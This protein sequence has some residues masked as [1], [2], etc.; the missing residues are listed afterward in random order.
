[1]DTTNALA[2]GWE[3]EETRKPRIAFMGEF[4][5]G[6]STLSNLLIGAPAL[7][8]KVTATQL[9][10][11][12]ISYGERAA[13]REDLEGERQPIELD[14]I[15]AFSHEQTR[16]LQVFQKAD[17][18]KL[19]DLI[20]MPGISD[21]NMSSD[22]WLPVV[23]H[24]DA[25]IWCT[26]A[27]QAWR[28]SEAAMWDEMRPELRKTSLLLITRFDKIL[29]QNDRDRVLSRIRHETAELFADCLPISLTRALA[30]RNDREMWE[31]SGAE[32]FMERMVELLHALSAKLTPENTQPSQP[33]AAGK[34]AGFAPS[35]AGPRARY[36]E[37]KP[38]VVPRRVTLSGDR[39]RRTR[40]VRT[41]AG[42]AC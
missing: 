14:E 8:V 40:P 27:T 32:V 38:R 30:A 33:H 17:I 36:V 22:V 35:E 34:V 31:E 3:N 25:V 18:L 15:G 11:V 5:A 9:P 42:T 13:F 41:A 21:P 10:P 7:P 24:A 37:E 19:C 4:S 6:K 29:N 2:F 16:M 26:H 20:D 12:W 28:Q 23:E 1:M 39:A